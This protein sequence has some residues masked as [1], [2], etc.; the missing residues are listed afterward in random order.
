VLQTYDNDP[1]QTSR[2]F[3][4]GR[5]FASDGVFNT[6]F[7]R[8]GTISKIGA[9]SIKD[10]CQFNQFVRPVTTAAIEDG[11]GRDRP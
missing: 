3:A 5:P 8:C 1:S 7:L 4:H 2:I 9:N 10:R 6:D 11:A